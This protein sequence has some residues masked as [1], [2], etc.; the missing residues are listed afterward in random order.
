MQKKNLIVGAGICGITLGRLL[1]EEL[2]E[3]VT[4]TDARA[5][6]GGQCYDYQT[7]EGITVHKYGPHIFR[8]DDERVWNYLSRF[9]RWRPY[10]HKVL[11]HIG[12]NQVPLPFNINSLYACFP[13]A[14]AR[15]LAEKLAARYGVNQTVPV[16]SLKNEAEPDLRALGEFVY[17]HIFLNYTRK[18]WG[19]L[20]EE[21]DASVTGS[22]PVYTGR[23][24]RYFRQAFQGVALHGYTRMFENMLSH[25]RI[26]VQ[27]NTPY[28]PAMA[29]GFDRVFY[30]GPIDEFFN[31]DLGEL[32]YRSLRFDVQTLPCARFQAAA[33]VNYP[34]AETYTRITEYKWFLEEA[35]S[36]TVV[37]YEYPQSFERGKNERYYPVPAA[38][39]RALYNQY[40]RRAQALGN[41]W[42]LGRLG[43][44]KYYNMAQAVA[45]A[46]AVFEQ[47]RP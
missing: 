9:T 24:D 19:L 11:A 27:L 47:I 6:V 44:Y 43:D 20:P 45:R 17:Q 3:S 29:A 42:F 4:L 40:A 37:A 35:S 32:P 13:P 2:G 38:A 46:R 36:H 34:G 39:S 5:H 15:E 10:V 31:Y 23:D 26:R 1:A 16:L 21:L 14:R 28:A 18:Q 12:G 25:P 22:V 41:M 8:T 33:V 7:P 30:T